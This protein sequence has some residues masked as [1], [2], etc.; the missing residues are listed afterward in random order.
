MAEQAECIF[1]RIVRGEI[2]ADIV[3][4]DARTSRFATSSRP[5]RRMCWSCRAS[6]SRRA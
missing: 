3:Y 5:L 2:P 1:C 6:T 4:Q